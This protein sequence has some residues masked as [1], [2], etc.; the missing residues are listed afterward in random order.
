MTI[1]LRS[2]HGPF[3]R[4]TD[5]VRDKHGRLLR[6]PLNVDWHFFGIR[7]DDTM[8]QWILRFDIRK[9]KYLIVNLPMSG[10]PALPEFVNAFVP[11]RPMIHGRNYT[12]IL[13]SRLSDDDVGFALGL[14]ITRTP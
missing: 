10:Q 3:K 7:E 2:L 14:T 9:R 1:F 8:G 5:E 11:D 6:G 13:R 12:A 4:S